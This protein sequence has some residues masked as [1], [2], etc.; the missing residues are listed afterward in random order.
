MKNDQA[1]KLWFKRRRYGW[2]YIPVTWQGA[3]CLIVFVGVLFA[4]VLQLPKNDTQPTTGQVI[5][6]LTMVA[7]D[8]VLLLTVSVV[9]GPSPHWRWGK[10]PGDNPDEDF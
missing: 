3:L 6:F 7:A 4:A 9:K 2:G 8:L 1:K 5:A 10:K